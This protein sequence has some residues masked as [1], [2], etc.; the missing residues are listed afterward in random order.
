MM[1]HAIEK[2]ANS[3]D[4]LVFLTGQYDIYKFLRLFETI[5]RRDDIYCIPC[6][7]GLPIDQQ[8]K[9]FEPAP[10]GHRKVI[11]S[12]NV[13]ETGLTIEGIGFVVD[14]CLTKITVYEP[15]L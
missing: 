12:S 14:S 2:D 10:Y 5:A 8:M 9:I 7:G 15:K 6:Y 3:G 1:I 11:A 13:A 4:I